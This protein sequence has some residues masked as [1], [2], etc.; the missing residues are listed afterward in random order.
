MAVNTVNA[1]NDIPFAY[2]RARAHENTYV[3]IVHTVHRGILEINIRYLA[4]NGNAA[5]RSHQPIER[6]HIAASDCGED[7]SRNHKRRLSRRPVK[8]RAFRS[9]TER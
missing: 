8:N 1:V 3:H 9:G 4:V 5:R 7:S 2:T 6:S